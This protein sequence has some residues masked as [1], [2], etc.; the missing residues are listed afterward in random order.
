[1]YALLIWHVYVLFTVFQL[2]EDDGRK[3]IMKDCFKIR[4]NL[5]L[6]I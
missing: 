5:A 6:H 2:Y 4:E 1:M 3:I